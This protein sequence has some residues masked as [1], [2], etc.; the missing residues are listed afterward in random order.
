MKADALSIN[1]VLKSDVVL[2]IPYFQR[3]YVWGE[4]SWERF[5]RGA[6][7]VRP[8]SWKVR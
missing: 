3:R 4:E 1:S 5:A 6:Y 2:R 8:T 7:N